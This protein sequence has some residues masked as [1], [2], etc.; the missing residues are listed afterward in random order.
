[1]CR[2]TDADANL[3]T[4]FPLLL[5]TL[6]SGNARARKSYPTHHGK[7]K[8]HNFTHTMSRR[9]ASSLHTPAFS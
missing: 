9:Q 3:D 8:A 4:L 6:D 1:M 2:V 7:R 5:W